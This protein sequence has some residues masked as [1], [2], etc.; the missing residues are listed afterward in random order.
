MWT[1]IFPFR[2][3]RGQSSGKLH[4]RKGYSIGPV[5]FLA[6]TA[7]RVTNGATLH[8][9][10]RAAAV[11][12]E[13]L[14]VVVWAHCAGHT[15]KRAALSRS[16]FLFHMALPEYCV[17][18]SAADTSGRADELRVRHS[19]A[20]GG[21]SA[22][23]KRANASCRRWREREKKMAVTMRFNIESVYRF[24]VYHQRLLMG[25]QSRISKRRPARG[26]LLSPQSR[27]PPPGVG[28]FGLAQWLLCG[29]VP[30]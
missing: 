24:E 3:C 19:T 2:S 16:L 6:A 13:C 28:E 14:V 25:R 9:L 4:A 23:S 30:R 26:I 11:K 1:L 20:T 27:M 8:L 7:A 12:S 10:Y 21:H 18:A 5:A 22:P 15:S 29:C 17:F